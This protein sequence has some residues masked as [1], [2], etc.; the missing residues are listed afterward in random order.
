[1]KLTFTSDLDI[2]GAG[3]ATRLLHKP[4]PLLLLRRCCEHQFGCDDCN[5][6]HTST[7]EAQLDT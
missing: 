2:L 3:G 7:V 5:H 1:M 4:E 6:S